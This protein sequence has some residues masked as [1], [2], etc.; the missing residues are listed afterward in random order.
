MGSN[1]GKIKI[2]IAPKILLYSGYTY[3][4]FLPTKT[5]QIMKPWGTLFYGVIH[6]EY[7]QIDVITISRATP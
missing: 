5:K 6:I 7:S 3:I 1:I 4:S 2:H